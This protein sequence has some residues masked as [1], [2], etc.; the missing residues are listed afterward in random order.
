MGGW[1]EQ[2]P[3][4]GTERGSSGRPCWKRGR[5]DATEGTR[6]PPW[7][8]LV[9]ARGGQEERLQQE[10][11]LYTQA[12]YQQSQASF[13]RTSLSELSVRLGRWDILGTLYVGNY[14][15]WLSCTVILFHHAL[16]GRPSSWE[17]E[18]VFR[19]GKLRKKKK[20]KKPFFSLMYLNVRIAVEALEPIQLFFRGFPQK[21]RVLPPP[22]KGYL[23]AQRVRED[24]ALYYS[25]LLHYSGR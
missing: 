20:E 6:C 23:S 16:E 1:A 18:N 24:T 4:H 9:A 14:W 7:G 21:S 2:H 13:Q 15:L 11:A 25:L 10:H 5:W 22:S 8:H 3:A 17:L 12:A 19:K